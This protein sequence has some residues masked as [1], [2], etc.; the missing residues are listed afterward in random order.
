MAQAQRLVDLRVVVERERRRLGPRRARSSL[1]DRQLDL[2]R[3]QLRVHR[4]LLAADDLAG[5]ADHVLG[6]HPLGERVRLRR[7]LRVEDDLQD[8]RA[9][10]QVDEHQA[11]V[12]AAAVHPAGHAHVL[13]D[14]RGVQLAG[15]CVAV[16]VGPRAVS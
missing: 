15:P 10:A 8:A 3:A 6:A 16:G 5:D 1:G 4:A 12:V 11:A 14:A 9:V 13:A 7:F 2:A